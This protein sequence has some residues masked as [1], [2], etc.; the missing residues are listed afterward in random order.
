MLS[1]NLSTT[2]RIH[3]D[4]SKARLAS[5]LIGIEEGKYLIIKMPPIYSVAD[6]S[7]LICKGNTVSV[8][9][10][11]KGSIFGFQSNII[12]VIYNPAK[13]IF[14]EYPKI[15]KDYDLRV[16]TRIDCL[17]PAKVIISDRTI[18]GSI[19]NIS[20]EGCQFVTKT[21]KIENNTGLMETN[22]E[23][24]LSFQL[25][26]VEKELSVTAKHQTISKDK[27][28]VIIGAKFVGIDGE[29]KEKIYNFLSVVET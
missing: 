21:S 24:S 26:G 8:R 10:M 29:I 3:V 23:I 11:H 19:T 7:S 13:L 9:Y 15:V 17:L 14:L 27:N 5:E 6:D 22:N 12:D 20:R 4:G 25:P 18:D 16:F 1:M 2:L 28:N